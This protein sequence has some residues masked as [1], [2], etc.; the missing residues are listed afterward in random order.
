MTELTVATRNANKLAELQAA[1]DRVH[2][3]PL[4]E[5]APEV[6]EGTES[7]EDNACLKAQSAAQYLGLPALADDTGF[8][9][10]AL[11]GAPGVL[12]ARFGGKGTTENDRREL[13]LER[14]REG[15][16]GLSRS[17]RYRTVLCLALPSGETVFADGVVEGVVASEQ[18]G[19]GGFGYDAIF[20]PAEGDGR[21]FAQMSRDEK[22]A[23]S[24]RG[25]AMRSLLE[26]HGVLL[27]G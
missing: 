24:H 3:R 18:R 9:V 7:L 2:L 1:S 19:E 13:V 21:T 14:L 20:M 22:S 8:Y 15:G 10:E 4:P 6:E 17:A 26:I 16:E 23:M 25:R 5:S 11:D 27:Q 12:S